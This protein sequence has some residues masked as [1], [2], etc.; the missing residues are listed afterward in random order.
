MPLKGAN[1][2][3]PTHFNIRIA[4]YSDPSDSK[5]RRQGDKHCSQKDGQN[6]NSG[7]PKEQARCEPTHHNAEAHSTDDVTS[8]N[9]S[10]KVKEESSGS[11]QSEKRIGNPGAAVSQLPSSFGESVPTIRPGA[12][13]SKRVLD[14]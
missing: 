2:C 3:D 11:N 4:F 1:S 7:Q 14:V 12:E 13:G 8:S 5:E 9:D 6:L 10:K